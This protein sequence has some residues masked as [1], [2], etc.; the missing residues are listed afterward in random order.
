MPSSASSSR[1][2]GPSGRRCSGSGSRK[3]ACL[4]V[5]DD[6]GVPGRRDGGGRERGEAAGAGPD[7]RLPLGPDRIERPLKRRL[8]PA[9]EPL[10]PTRFEVGAAGLDRLH[11]Q[12]GLLEPAQDPLPLLLDP[13]RVLLDELERRTGGERLGEAHARSYARALGDA[14]TGPQER[15]LP[16]RR[17]ERDRLPHE[18]RPPQERGAKG[19]RRDR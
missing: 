2:S 1:R 11:R 4:A 19:E 17:R 14:G 5:V 12:A 9:R 16:R 6:D 3:S 18:I 7:A 10:D 13:G 15:L 8:E